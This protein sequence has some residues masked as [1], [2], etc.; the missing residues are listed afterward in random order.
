M[1]EGSEREDV[2]VD[3]KHGRPPKVGEKSPKVGGP[4]QRPSKKAYYILK[5]AIV[6][7]YYSLEKAIVDI[8]SSFKKGIVCWEKGIVDFDSLFEKG[9]SSFEEGRR[10]PYFV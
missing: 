4:F 3:R 7:F 9:H 5:K 10:R 8:D 1:T 2:T 6:D